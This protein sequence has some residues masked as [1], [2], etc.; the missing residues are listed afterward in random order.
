MLSRQVTAIALRLMALWLLVKLVFSLPTLALLL[1]SV[2]TLPQGDT[3][4]L[5]LLYTGG[6]LLV[7][8][9]AIWLIDRAARSALVRVGE[10]APD[11]TRPLSHQAQALMFQLLGLYFLISALADLPG[12]LAFAPHVDQLTWPQLL[13]PAGQ[14]FQLG[15]GLWLAAGSGFWIRLC[16][17]LRGR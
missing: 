15:M 11:E 5:F 13:R 1:Q 17:R 10:A 7:G 8:L 2:E 4:A 16:R 14:A 3:P 9:L 12:V 6:F